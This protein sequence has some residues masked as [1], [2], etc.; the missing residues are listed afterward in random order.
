MIP[1]IGQPA[2]ACR[3]RRA[4][5]A[6]DLS[7]VREGGDPGQVHDLGVPGVHE[8]GPLIE[9]ADVRP[10][11]RHAI[12]AGDGQLAVRTLAAD[13]P[14]LKLPDTGSDQPRRVTPLA[15]SLPARRVRPPGSPRPGAP[16]WGRW[17]H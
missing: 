14:P 4:G 15:A 1:R 9:G 16:L 2:P 5:R 12:D 13:A 8:P 6:D 10:L 3:A 11:L 17:C 7:R